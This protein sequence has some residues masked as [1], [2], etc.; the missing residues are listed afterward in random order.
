VLVVLDEEP[1]ELCVLVELELL[2]TVL[3]LLLDRLLAELALL[4]SSQPRTER[5]PDRKLSSEAVLNLIRLGSPFTPPRTSVS[6]TSKKLLTSSSC[7]N[8]ST[9]PASVSW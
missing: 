9:V 8:S 7:S 5:T 3:L 4:R 1:L 6:S 2:E